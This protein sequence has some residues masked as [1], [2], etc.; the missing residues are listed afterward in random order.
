MA[1]LFLG[2]AATSTAAIT[3]AAI[4]APLPPIGFNKTSDAKHQGHGHYNSHKY[5]IHFLFPLSGYNQRTDLVNCHGQSKGQGGVKDDRK[6]SPLS[7][8]C[9]LCN[10]NHRDKT[11]G[12][13]ICKNNQAECG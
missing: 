4:A 13:K 6:R 12:I 1:C 7:G 3:T 2:P 8:A 9:F 5:V 11:G 10:T